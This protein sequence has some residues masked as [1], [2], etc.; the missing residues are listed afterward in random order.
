MENYE[1][2]AELLPPLM[3]S[4]DYRLDIDYGMDKN[5][6]VIYVQLKVYVNLRGLKI[7]DFGMG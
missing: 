6:T 2:S 1:M 5:L 3:P 7:A 4:G